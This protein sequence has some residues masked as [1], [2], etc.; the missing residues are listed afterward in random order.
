MFQVVPSIDLRGGK[1]VRLQQG[2]YQRQLNYDLDPCETARSFQAAGAQWMHLVDLDGAKEGSIAQ[3]SLIGQIIK[4]TSLKV[5]VGGGVR[6]DEDVRRLLGI[7]ASR[8]VVGTRAIQDWPWFTKLAHQQEFADR[9]VLAV[10][11]RDGRVATH[12]WT[13]TTGRLAVDI[14]AEVRGW[15][16][17]GLLYTDVAKDG[18]LQGPNLETT[19]SLAQATDIPVI[20]SGGVGSIEHIKSLLTLPVWGVIVGRSLHDGRLDLGQAVALA[21]TGLGTS[22]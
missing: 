6:S 7:G 5:Q 19:R 3:S 14:A 16:V 2:D 9:L 11:A 10:D 13:Q 22:T 4:S 15:P 17:A 21:Q 1:V 20:A 12:G 8:V 18:M